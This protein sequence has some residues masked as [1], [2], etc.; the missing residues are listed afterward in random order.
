M[1]IA[2]LWSLPYHDYCWISSLIVYTY[3]SKF[4]I[5]NLKFLPLMKGVATWAVAAFNKQVA[6][7]RNPAGTLE[8]W[9]SYGPFEFYFVLSPFMFGWV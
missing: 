7:A 8:Q 4:A 5:V 3:C 9:L 6:Q 2:G 1:I